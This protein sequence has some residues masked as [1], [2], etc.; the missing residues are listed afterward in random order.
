MCFGKK[1]KTQ[2]QQQQQQQQHQQNKSQTLQF[3]PQPRMHR[4]LKRFL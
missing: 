2:Q 4:S 1:V 3:L